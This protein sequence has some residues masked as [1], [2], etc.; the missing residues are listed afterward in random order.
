MEPFRYHVFVC[1]QEK[2][3]GVPCCAASGSGAVLDALRREL[4]A[5]GLS[6]EVQVSSSGCLGTCEH[7]PVMIAYPEGAW[8]SELKA[9]DVA[10]IV[11]S[12]F[13]RGQPVSRL[14]RTEAQAMKTEIL[15]H[16]DHYL[17]MLKAK[18]AAGGLPDDL[19]ETIRGF[20]GS[21]AIL[22][23]IEL[24][25]F[26]ALGNGAIA[27]EV[28]AKIKAEARSTEMLLNA[29]VALKLLQKSGE[30]FQNTPVSR[31]FFT[32]GSPDNARP[33]QMHTV[34]LWRRW[35]TLT[36]AVAAGTRV[37]ERGRSEEWTGSFIAAMDHNAR[38]RAEAVVKAAG[39]NGARR[40]LDLGGGSGAYTVAF[41]TA[42]P[43]LRGEILDLP[44]VLPITQEHLRRAG[45]AE[46]ITTRAGD[47]LQAE[48][49]ND[50]DL[51]LL[52]AICH[53]F[54][55]EENRELLRRIYQA[56]APNGRVVVQDFILD[57]DKTSP[58][59][60]ALF[61][62]N[63]LVGTKAGASYSEP[64]YTD[65]MRTAGFREI[66]RVR[67]PGPSGLMIGTK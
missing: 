34:N 39:V 52:S 17:A 16:R 40:M 26:S 24:D 31:R 6:D 25:V 44:D 43:E 15:E 60:A 45:V 12:H 28:A 50:Y 42:A 59:F 18:D 53:M 67:M 29:L 56:L 9:A 58:K 63:M 14:A 3:E 4:G 64:E 54:S 66:K 41:A 36:D 46:R 7:G 11:A 62:L 38:G 10:E 30:T 2:P 61:S 23:A 27:A 22:T 48:L 37:A 47:M 33:A 20:M 21:R 49:G 8:Y 55:P 51:V 1:T 35:S 5:R 57:A 65:W 32:A 19:N 13:D